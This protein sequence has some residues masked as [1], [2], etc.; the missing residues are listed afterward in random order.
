MCTEWKENQIASPF[1]RAKWIWHKEI[2]NTDEYAVFEDSFEC[3]NENVT[4]RICAETNYVAYLNGNMIAY[5]QFAGYRN[6]K[7]Y[8]EIDVS[9]FCKKGKNVLEVSV[10]YEG[11]NSATHIDDGAGLIFEVLNGTNVVCYSDTNTLGAIDTRYIGGRSKAITVQLGYTSG[12]V[13]ANTQNKKSR[14]VELGRKEVRFE[15][16]PVKK[17]LDDAL[18]VGR[19]IDEKRSLYDL[20]REEAGY[21]FLEV[22]CAEDCKLTVGYGEH[23]YDGEVKRK[24]GGGYKNAGRDFS[25]DFICKRGNNKF[26]NRF[27]RLAG[28]YLQ[29]YCDNPFKIKTIGL[30]PVYYPVAERKFDFLRGTDKRIYDTCVRTLR[31]CMHE[32]YEDCPWREQALY[33]LDSRNQML[34]GYYAFEESDFQRANLVFMSHGTREDGLLELTYPAINTPAIPFFSLMYIVALNEYVSHTQDTRILDEVWKTV[35]AIV[36][37]FV[38]RLG[39]NHLIENFPAPY[40]NFYEWS[41]GSDNSNELDAEIPRVKKT[42]LLLNCA[43]VYSMTAY[44]NL[45]KIK[46]EKGVIELERVR[47]A[48]REHFYDQE[49]NLYFLSDVDKTYSQ[50]GNA[51]AVLIGLGNEGIIESIKQDETLIPATLSMLGFVYDALLTEKGNED[52]IINDIRCKYT[53]MLEKGATS[54]WE[55]IEGAFVDVAQSLCHGWSAIPIYYY[56]TIL[57][58]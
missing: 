27:L 10:W 19:L 20:G 40:W 36:T 57:R 46:G 6:I 29:V 13:N 42:D 18:V 43:F 24:I 26:E 5:G 34:C 1:Q 12:M 7:Y 55:T 58:K 50:L 54:F 15:K 11:F 21:L 9:A 2:Y 53:Y 48:I 31:L 52:F 17:L 41:Q 4:L 23:I 22:E 45:C 30:I 16:R 32:H 44:N 14:C 35:Q 28:R 39:E 37:V 33:S 51:F 3:E 38:K 25:L 49:R 56:H 47:N 8:D